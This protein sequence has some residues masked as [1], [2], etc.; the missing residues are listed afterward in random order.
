MLARAEENHK[1]SNGNSGYGS[2]ANMKIVQSAV[3]CPFFSAKC[4]KK[5]I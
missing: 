5:Y 3:S 2:P 1:V 4:I